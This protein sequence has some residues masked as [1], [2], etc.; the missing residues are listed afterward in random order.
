MA[1]EAPEVTGRTIRLESCSRIYTTPG[2]VAI[3]ALDEVSVDFPAGSITALC[4][5]SG[6]GK[7]TLL[8]LVGGMDRADSGSILADREALSGLSTSQLVGY[9]RTVG[10]V[11][12]AFALLPALT[13]RD[14]VML[15]V[16]PYRSG[17]K[18]TD[19]ATELLAEVGLKGRE[20]AIPSQMSGG[21]RQRVAIARAI[22]KNPA[23]LILDEA[24]SSLD[25]ESERLMQLALDKLME[26][27]TTFMI[28][29][30]LATV[31]RADRILVIEGG[32][33]VESGTHSELNQQ[34]NGLYRRLAELQF[35]VG[36]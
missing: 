29:H 26:N 22:L 19:R 6:S 21:Q 4:G 27:R 30:R 24:T 33:L 5:P 9:R 25:S 7:S 36:E 35:N 8:H 14:N 34:D 23:I 2:G 12:Q 18:D 16:L 17:S 1:E 15:P 31:R 13:A 3:R 20:D 10:F 28:A 32:K 11:F